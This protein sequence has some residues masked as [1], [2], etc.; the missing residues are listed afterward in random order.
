MRGTPYVVRMMT[1]LSKPKVPR[2]GAD[3]SGQVESV[4]LNVTKFKPGDEVF[5][6]CHGAFAEYVCA[7]QSALVIKPAN[8]TF[9]QAASAPVAAFTALQGLRDKGHIQS[10]HRQVVRHGC[11]G[12]MQH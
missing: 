4:G 5:G 11:D 9:E 3:V 1:G 10:G 8:V 2:L 7:S 12:R 6:S